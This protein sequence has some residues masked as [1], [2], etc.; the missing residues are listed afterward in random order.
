MIDPRFP[1]QPETNSNT[2]FLYPLQKELNIISSLESLT[3]NEKLKN[4]IINEIN[5]LNNIK[6]ERD[7]IIF[8]NT[9]SA[10]LFEYLKWR[11]IKSGI[12]LKV[13]LPAYSCPEVCC[14]IIKS[15]AE[16][17]FLDFDLKYSYSKRSIKFAKDR[18]TNIILWPNFF[19]YRKRNKKILNYIDE[20]NI[21]II[22]DEAQSFP[23]GIITVNY[24]TLISLGITKRLSG[25]GGGAL[26]LPNKKEAES[27]SNFIK[28]S[29]KKSF[30]N[31][32]FITTI[33]FLKRILYLGTC[34]SK[35]NFEKE[36]PV[37]LEKKITAYLK[38]DFPS[39]SIRNIELA[40][41]NR[42]LLQLKKYHNEIIN[43]YEKLSIF[44]AKNFGESSMDI[45]SDVLE[46]PTIF[47]VKLDPKKRYIV[48][49][50]LSKIKIQ[51]T[52]YYYPLN[53]VKVFSDYQSEKTPN[54]DKLASEILILPFNLRHCLKNNSQY[55]KILSKRVYGD[56]D[57]I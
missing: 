1:P 14:A 5:L 4:K 32:L 27:F 33:K 37:L 24:K 20:L 10:C 29:K 46:Y 55:L 18:G 49:E 43:L 47:A 50:W 38:K 57:N 16:P 3:S 7:S 6:I 45:I 26:L 22:L 52:W 34:S 36:L 28:K 8:L 11:N 53:R 21:D 41:A 19:G 44:C 39:T 9:A 13:A 30:Q 25:I 51:T 40:I 42:R 31:Q 17:I 15:G 2:I 54:S 12:P 35:K 23:S 56:N 48:S